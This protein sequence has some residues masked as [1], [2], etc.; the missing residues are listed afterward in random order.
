MIAWRQIGA[1][2]WRESRTARRRLLLYMSS[3]S[4][5]VAALVAIDSFSENVTR[6]VHEQSRALTGGDISIT[7]RAPF[8]TT[9]R[10]LMDSLDTHG[11]A[12]ARMTSFPSM[13]LVDRTGGT[14]LIQVRAISNGYPYYGEI[15]SSPPTAWPAL[16]AGANAVVDPSLLV[17]LGARIG[18]TLSL[19]N[20]RFV[21]SGALDKVPGEFGITA[22]I[23]PRVYISESRLATTGLLIVGSRAEY[24]AVAKLPADIQPGSFMA[25]FS[26]R[27]VRDSLRVRTAG[28]NEERLATTIDQLRDFLA[29]VALVALLLGGV[30]VASGVHAFVMGKL[31]TVAVLRCLG[32]T[33]AQ[34]LLI[35]I[36]QAA[37]MGLIGAA[38][39]GA[40]GIAMQFALPAALHDFLPLNVSIQTEPAAVALGMGIGVWVAMVFALRP[41]VS[42]RRVSPLQAL[43]R[44]T[45]SDV[46]R[47][48]RRDSMTIVVTIAIIASVVGLALTRAE[49]V[50]QGMI[51]SAAI[52]GAIGALAGAAELLSLAARRLARPGVPF[53]NRQGI[54]ALYRPGNQTRS[55]VLALGFGVFLI[56]TLYQVQHN[57]LR[58][59]DVRLDE[60]RGNVMFFDVHE[61]QR[62]G[63]DSIIRAAGH[64]LV[65]TTP[66]V[67]MRIDS[68]NGQ[69]AGAPAR[70][71]QR[72]VVRRA[73]WAARREYNSTYR[74]SMAPGERIVAGRW[75]S[76]PPSPGALPEISVE[77]GVATEL[78]LALGDTVT[79]NIQ[80][81]RVTTRVT[82]YREVKWA[83]FQPNFFVVFQTATLRDAP[84]Q[85]V[86]LANAPD[87]T[88]VA[89]LQRD[90]VAKYP[91]VSS[92][93]LTLV[94][95]TVG[96]VIGKV[97]MAMRFLAML[98]VGLAIPVLFSAVTATRRQRVREGVLLKTLGATRYQIG[99]IMLAE[100]ALLGILGALTGGLLSMVASWA[101]TH[102]VFKSSYAPA[103][104]PM[105]AVTTGII[106][107][108]VGI[109]FLTGRE[110]FRE[111]PMAALR[112][113]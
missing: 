24:E 76:G 10:A 2:A 67:K 11:V 55:V 70:P 75:F 39:G 37:A 52:A 5:G 61:D 30:G 12:I 71:G 4:F 66:L 8:P 68:I 14:R 48:T 108:A 95:R 103:L 96:D 83:S 23:G 58:S 80:G 98:S 1:L 84:T 42:L 88:A 64:A 85:Y 91:A 15:T 89:L 106:A 69:G 62:A 78:G 73:G 35:Y 110:V 19:G 105:L 74:D 72:G 109:G 16:H 38:A 50:Q 13:A 60:S 94:Q 81:V 79:W 53:P 92:I 112:E 29:L 111:T 18:D 6:S 44:A 25:R 7:G 27:F 46:V 93:D 22:A 100:Y 21:I 77:D 47:Q 26:G 107:L 82:S 86:M 87:P 104:L 36:A 97:T 49:T 90:I 113:S 33:G 45:D 59:L 51:Y 65:Q 41:L 34:V 63:I 40:I 99:R 31:D 28:Y 9:S 102:W 20:A 57:L 43:R 54:A 17:S 32:A 56:G 101:L 3:I